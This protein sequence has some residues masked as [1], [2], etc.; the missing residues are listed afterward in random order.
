MK[1]FLVRDFE[2]SDAEAVTKLAVYYFTETELGVRLTAPTEAEVLTWKERYNTFIVV[3]AAASHKVVGFAT[4]GPSYLGDMFTVESW[5]DP[6]YLDDGAGAKLQEAIMTKMSTLQSNCII[7][8]THTLLPIVD[9]MG[10]DFPREEVG[11]LNNAYRKEN[12]SQHLI[13]YKLLPSLSKL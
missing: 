2:P 8:I 6:H 4:I 5:V 12:R 9:K 3:E 10:M 7:I 1:V 13:F 11:R